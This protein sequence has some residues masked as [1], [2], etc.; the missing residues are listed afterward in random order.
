MDNYSRINKKGQVALEVSMAFGA[1]VL[2]LVG[3]VSIWSWYN[4]DIAKRQPAY[5][6]TREEAG[7]SGSEHW[8]VYTPVPLNEA[9]VLP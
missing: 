6:A 4:N 1:T 2:L 5:N 3:I 9:D 7:S 8:P